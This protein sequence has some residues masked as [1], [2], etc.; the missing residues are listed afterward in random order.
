M[1]K[2]SGEYIAVKLPEGID[3]KE[4]MINEYGSLWGISNLNYPYRIQSYNTFQEHQII[5]LI[6]EIIDYSLKI[7]NKPIY[8]WADEF[9]VAEWNQW[10]I[11]KKIKE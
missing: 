7:S 6:S 9:P 4:F 1:I 10:L 3:F 5:G 2:Q 8:E 11:I